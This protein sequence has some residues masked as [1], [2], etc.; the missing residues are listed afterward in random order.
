FGTVTGW[1]VSSRDWECV[2]SGAS[3]ETGLAALRFTGVPKTLRETLSKTSVPLKGAGNPLD[4]SRSTVKVPVPTVSPTA[5]VAVS[6]ETSIAPM[7]AS[8]RTTLRSRDPLMAIPSLEQRDGG[9][10]LH[11]V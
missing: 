3:T 2:M 9:W 6:A 11:G 10:V 5:S 7:A 8:V 1:N 4:R